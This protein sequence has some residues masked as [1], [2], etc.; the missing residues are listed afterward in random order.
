MGFYDAFDPVPTAYCYA[1]ISCTARI[2]PA[3]AGLLTD[4]MDVFKIGRLAPCV[5]ANK[6]CQS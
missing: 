2:K 4:R 1:K 5:R 3:T 6:A